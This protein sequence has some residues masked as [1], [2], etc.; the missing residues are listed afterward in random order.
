MRQ[1]CVDRALKLLNEALQIIDDLGNRPEVG[2][3]LQH[4]IDSL[5]DGSGMPPPNAV[6]LGPI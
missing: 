3:R 1:T 4:V 2:A 5:S 6:Q